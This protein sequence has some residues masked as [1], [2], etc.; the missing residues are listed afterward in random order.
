MTSKR[1]NFIKAEREYVKSIVH[2]L[3]VQRLTDR[4]I[5]EWLSTEKKIE[6]DRSTISRIRNHG[7]KEV[8]NPPLHYL[9]PVRYAAH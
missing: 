6:L 9:H 4:E 3:S 1:A 7:E 2:N 5:V 8:D